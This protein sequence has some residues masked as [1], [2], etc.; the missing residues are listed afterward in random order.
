VK[1]LLLKEREGTDRAV[2]P[3]STRTLVLGCCSA[4]TPISVNIF[5][6]FHSVKN[7]FEGYY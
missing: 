4:K 2:K 1:N 6:V 5:L 7:M 3:L